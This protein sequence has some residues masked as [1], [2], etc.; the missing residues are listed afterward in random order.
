MPT[1]NFVDDLNGNLEG[2]TQD[3]TEGLDYWE[4][5]YREHEEYKY[6]GDLVAEDKKDL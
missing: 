1:G 5:F 6:V 2:L 3:Q 4:K